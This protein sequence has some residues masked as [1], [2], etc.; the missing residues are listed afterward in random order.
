MS[1]RGRLTTASALV[2]LVVVSAVLFV[3]GG[4]RFG[5]GLALTA[6]ETDLA[7]G[8]SLVGVSVAL[9]Q[10][11]S[12]VAMFV[13]GRSADRVDPARVLFVGILIAAAGSGA[14][15]LV[16]APWQLVVLYGVV[17]A[18]GNGVASLIPIGVLV[19]RHFPARPGLANAIALAGLGLGQLA[20][21]A[22]MT[23]VL[24]SRGWRTVFLWLGAAHLA[25]LPLILLIW[26]R[27]P[28]PAPVAPAVPV[29]NATAA[30][31][32]PSVTVAAALRTRHLWL[33]LAI[34]ALCGFEDFFVSTHIVAFAQDR[35]AGLL[36]AGNL[37]AFMGLAALIGVIA[38]GAGA[39]RIGA[40][41]ATILCFA[42]RVGLFAWILID[43]S[44]PS[45]AM[46]ALMFGATFLVTAPLTV[47]FVR[48][49]FG[50]RNLGALTGLITMV[51][52]ICGGFGAWL[53]AQLFD[54]SRDYNVV[55]AMMLA[56]SVAGLVLS[57]AVGRHRTPR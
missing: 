25:L 32:A 8:R 34:Y 24:E 37:L 23:P 28:V 1:V 17:F 51:H 36:L 13:A 6:I 9:F 3:G 56:S 11:V 57:L 40:A 15:S 47:V 22:A 2:V 31:P 50:T 14:L 10:I 43:Q 42:V 49:A 39:D 38:A 35:G 19:T 33:L 52:H 7:S 53:G 21:M 45:V 48:E 16:S 20:I 30:G 41:G 26:A 46:F 27:Q 29:A 4:S 5:I 18:V 44:T 54:V 55:L 12:A